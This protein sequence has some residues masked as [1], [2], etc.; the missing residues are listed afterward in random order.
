MVNYIGISCGTERSTYR[1]M[2]H[3]NRYYVRAV[4]KAGAIPVLIPNVSPELAKEYLNLVDGLIL[5]GGDDVASWRFH[6]GPSANVSV[7]DA[8]RDEMEEALFCEAYRR[9]MPILGICRGMQYMNILLGGDLYQ[10]IPTQMKGAYNHVSKETLEDGFHTITLDKDGWLGRW[11]NKETILVNSEHHQA[12]KTV[13][14][15][16]KP[17]AYSDDGIIEGVEGIDG[18][19]YGVQFHPEA[20][21]EKHPVMMKIFEGFIELTKEYKLNK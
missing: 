8:A 10:D 7:F 20:M 15:E 3:L 12:L 5:S 4:E 13:A 16:L 9:Q 1:T 19:V 17:V 21:V 2:V 11:L 14:K 18:P 6:M